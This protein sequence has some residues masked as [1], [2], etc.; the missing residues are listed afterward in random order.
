MRAQNFNNTSNNRSAVTV[1]IKG[2]IDKSSAPKI[3]EL[4]TPYYNKNQRAIIVDLT[5][6]TYIDSTGI[7]TL[8]EGLQWSHCSKNKFRLACLRP[9]VKDVFEIVHLLRI[10]D[11]FETKEDALAEFERNS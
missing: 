4:L 1:S 6:V 3:R 5:D 7:A 11:V 2:D 8:V 9:T 10:F